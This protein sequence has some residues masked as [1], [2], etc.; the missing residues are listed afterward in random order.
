MSQDLVGLTAIEQIAGYRRGDFSP[1][2][3]AAAALAEA[4]RLQPGLNPFLLID[5]EGATGAARAS[6]ERWRAG[7]PMGPLDGVTTTIKDVVR[8]KG[9]PCRYGSR[10]TPEAA[11]E[12]DAPAVARLRAAGAVLIGDTTTPEFGW[13][14]VTDSPLTG[15]TRNPWN[16][17]RTPGG[18]S[19]GA[20]VATAMG[21]AALN[22][23]TDGGGSVRIPASFSGVFGLKPSFARV[24]AWPASPFGSL[25]HIGP[26][27]RTVSDAALMLN[28]ISAPDPR[29]WAPLPA[30]DVDY[31]D[32]LEAGIAGLKIGFSP[33]LGG[34]RVDPEVAALVAA[35][36]KRFEELG[37]EVTEADPDLPEDTAEMMRCLWFAGAAKLFERIAESVRSLMDSGLREIAEAGARYSLFDYLEAEQRRRDIG[38]AMSRFH[39]AYD[40]LLTPTMPLT[41]FEAGREMPPDTGA[42]RWVD[43]TPFTYPFNMTGQPAASLPCGFSRDGLPVGVQ[44]VGPRHQDGLVLRASRAFEQAQP[45]RMTNML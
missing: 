9:W 2:E 28:V 31:L 18:S 35:A 8:T 40:L 30:N 38:L 36:A 20:A 43:W 42:G 10:T 5:H 39:A 16:P 13:K 44:I 3:V 12:E 17:E 41:A 22:I 45:F 32:G 37:A 6:T 27:T 7:R 4:E 29:D 19:G 34:Q 21:V 26:L 11:C 1:S 23:G 25:A 14:G 24:P 15:I 33:T